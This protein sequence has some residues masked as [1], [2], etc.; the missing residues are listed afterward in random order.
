LTCWFKISQSAGTALFCQ[1]NDRTIVLKDFDSIAALLGDITTIKE[2]GMLYRVLLPM[3]IMVYTPEEAATTIKVFI[4]E[5]L[6]SK[7]D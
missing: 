4:V 2:D 6:P 1:K 7:A 3:D 5:R